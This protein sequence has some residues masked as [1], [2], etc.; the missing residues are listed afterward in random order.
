MQDVV[1]R[2][3]VQR[4]AIPVF[5]QCLGLRRR[6]QAITETGDDQAPILGHQRRVVQR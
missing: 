1:A 6:G 2:E 3:P 5:P 4:T